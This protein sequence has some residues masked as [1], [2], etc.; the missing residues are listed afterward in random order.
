MKNLNT[1]GRALG[2]FVAVSFLSALGEGPIKPPI[3]S[4]WAEE[5][6]VIQPDLTLTEKYNG[7][8]LKA[9]SGK[10]I[11]VRLESNA[12]TGYEWTVSKQ[13]EEALVMI[14]KP[15]FIAPKDARA[16]AAGHQVFL[17]KT[18]KTGPT[19]LQLIYARP[20]ETGKPPVQTFN[21]TIDIQ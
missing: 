1:T 10:I 18:K 15:I 4:A 21:V 12:T 19:E 5:A 11:E 20:F 2:L 16:G 17:F 9:K 14:A 3:H 6:K 7:N 8:T 13:D